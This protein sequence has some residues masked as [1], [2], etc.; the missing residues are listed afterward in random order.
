MT[1]RDQWKA[2]NQSVPG[3]YGEITDG[4]G[5]SLVLGKGSGKEMGYV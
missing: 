1:S 5:G 4:E 3:L 2:I